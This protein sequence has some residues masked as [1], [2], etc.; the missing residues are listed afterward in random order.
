MPS[1]SAAA[2]RK[3][4]QAARRMLWPSSL[5]TLGELGDRGRLARPVDAGDQVDRRLFGRDGER[6]GAG[7]GEEGLELSLEKLDQVVVGRLV[8]VRFANAFDD[9]ASRRDA[10]VGLDQLGLEVVKERLVDLP[11]EPRADVE[12]L[13]CLGQARLETFEQ[14]FDRHR[15]P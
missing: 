5:E 2:A 12:D 11:I 9:L 10:D 15:V 6:A 14:G 8:T 3:V 4:S 1:W 13:S 7:V